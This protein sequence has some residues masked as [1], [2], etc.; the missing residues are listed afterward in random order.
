MPGFCISTER[1]PNPLSIRQLS[2]VAT[3]I[4]RILLEMS[5]LCS[6]NPES[7]AGTSGAADTLDHHKVCQ[8]LSLDLRTLARSSGRSQEDCVTAMHLLVSGVISGTCVLHNQQQGD[9]T[10]K[11]LRAQYEERLLAEWL[12]PFLQNLGALIDDANQKAAADDNAGT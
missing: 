2:P 10:S 1:D 4:I 9:L 12:A 3:A 7:A 6:E 8:H 11:E 5:L